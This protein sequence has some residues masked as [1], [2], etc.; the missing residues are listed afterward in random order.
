MGEADALNEQSVLAAMRHIVAHGALS[1]TKA[2]QWQLQGLYQEGQ[3]RLK[4]LSCR[5][6]DEL[7]ELVARD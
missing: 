1:P 4:L 6:L 2:A 5:L 3:K 7:L